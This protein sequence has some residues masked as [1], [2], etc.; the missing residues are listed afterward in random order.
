MLDLVPQHEDQ[1]E[2]ECRQ[3]HGGDQEAEAGAGSLAPAFDL[4]P[5]S[6]AVVAI[7]LLDRARIDRWVVRGCG[8]TVGGLGHWRIVRG[9][10]A[11]AGRL[12]QTL[13]RVGRWL[14]V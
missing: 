2:R 4:S 13:V 10:L 12:D 7:G 11:R 8:D 1:H 9:R 14:R 5:A 3:G 6:R